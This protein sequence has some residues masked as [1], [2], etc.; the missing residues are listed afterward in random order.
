M[1][2]EEFLR[3]MAEGKRK[4]QEEESSLTTAT[5]PPV[6]SPEANLTAAKSNVAIV[7]DEMK[8]RK[9]FGILK[10]EGTMLY[11]LRTYSI[12]GNQVVG[13]EDS[14]EDLFGMVMGRLQNEVEYD[15]Q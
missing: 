11:F 3:K 6:Q 5:T 9:A 13:Q 10:R 7:A 1:E 14:V 2:R 12:I 4:K 15:N 8:I